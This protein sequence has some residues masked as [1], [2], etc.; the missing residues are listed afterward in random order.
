MAPATRSLMLAG[1]LG[2]ASGAA[3]CAEWAVAPVLF[4]NADYQSNRTL[5][6]GTPASQSLGAS[7]NLDLARRTEASEFSIAPY[8]FM[9]RLSPKVDAD[10]NDLR[11][12]ASLRLNFERA[13]LTLDAS[14]A[15]ESTLTTELAETG[16]IRPDSS[17]I[18]RATDAAWLLSQSDAWQLNVSASFQDVN[19]TGDNAGQLYDYR[20]GDLSATES[21]AVSPRGNWRV[22]AFAS[23]LLS[24]QRTGDSAEAGLSVGYDFSWTEYTRMSATL[25]FSRRDFD[26]AREVGRVG[27]FSLSHDG[28]INQWKLVIDQSMVPY[29]SGTLTERDTAE[30]LMTHRFDTRL[31]A[32]SRLGVARNEDISP[33][34]DVDAR[35]YRYADTELRWQVNETWSASVV[36]GFADAQDPGELQRVGGWTLEIR[37]NWFPQRHVLGH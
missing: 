33:F 10:L 22:G 32:V 36:A 28:E 3:H 1:S 27:N 12:P 19:Y 7:L 34:S 25:G 13:V 29:G 35:T 2:L 15:D 18:M 31:Q 11:I 23:K 37:T 20:Y 24:E 26:G 14:Y 5:R 4:F 21:F 8:Y 16:A 30:L 17:R 6:E 9:R